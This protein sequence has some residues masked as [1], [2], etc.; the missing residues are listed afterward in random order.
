MWNHDRTAIIGLL[1]AKDLILIS[2]ASRIPL[3]AVVHFFRRESVNVV[4]DEDTLEAV[5]RIFSSSRQHF[6]I[7]RT[8]DASGPG[9]PVYKIGGIITMEDILETIIKSEIADE[10]DALRGDVAADAAALAASQWH[11]GPGEEEAGSGGRDA[12]V[13]CLATWWRRKRRRGWRGR[14]T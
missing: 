6:A 10:Y 8:V 12:C 4:E 9:D 1:Y 3:V 11:G 2:P 5:L 14:S 7:V 13:R